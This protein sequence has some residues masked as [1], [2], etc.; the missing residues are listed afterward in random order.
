MFFLREIL[1]HSGQNSENELLKTNWGGWVMIKVKLKPEVL[2][3]G[4]P[5]NLCSEILKLIGNCK[6]SSRCLQ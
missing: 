2:G 5:D 1:V 4:S 6:S 3:L